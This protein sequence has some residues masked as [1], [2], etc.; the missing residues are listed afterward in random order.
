MR[1]AFA[2]VSLGLFLLRSAQVHHMALM[3]F[4]L[5]LSLALG[6]FAA[7]ARVEAGYENELSIAQ[8]WFDASFGEDVS[9]LPFSFKLGKESSAAVLGR[10]KRSS[11]DKQL[12]GNRTERTI[13]WADETTGLE[14]KVVVVKYADY[15]NIEWTVRFTNKGDKAAGPTST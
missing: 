9:K 14:T 6:L 10:A 5:G 8:Q 13:V 4:L 1:L 11:E 15:P 3:R 2:A 7:A 12:D